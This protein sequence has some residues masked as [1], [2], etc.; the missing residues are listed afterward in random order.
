M[1]K[2]LLTS[3]LSLSI[4]LLAS[5][6]FA[7][8]QYGSVNSWG[9]WSTG[10]SPAAGGIAIPQSSVAPYI[11]TPPKV[12]KQPELPAPVTPPPPPVA[13]PAVPPPPPP[14][15]P[16][17]PGPPPP[18]PIVPAPPVVPPPPPPPPPPAPPV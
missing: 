16:P 10:V 3:L 7:V 15:P 9:T 11:P 12:E 14:P 13:A 17:V 2:V 5:Q 8:G 18:A 4:T 1:K 6:S